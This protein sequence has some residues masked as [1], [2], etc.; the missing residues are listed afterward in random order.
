MIFPFETLYTGNQLLFATTLIRDFSEMKWKRDKALYT[1]F[2][3][4]SFWKILVCG[5]KHPRQLGSHETRDN[6]LHTN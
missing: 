1:P 6:F 3:I 4:T 2:F 5:E